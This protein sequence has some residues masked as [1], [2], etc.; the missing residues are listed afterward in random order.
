MF[1]IISYQDFV[2]TAA[3]YRTQFI[4]TLNPKVTQH[5]AA[6]EQQSIIQPQQI[7]CEIYALK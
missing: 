2:F 3:L 4:Y 6:L 1:S 7:K 5:I